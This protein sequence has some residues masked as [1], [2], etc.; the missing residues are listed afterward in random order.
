MDWKIW[1]LFMWIAISIDQ[2]GNTVCGALFNKVLITEEWH[3]FWDEDETISSAIWINK[4]L[5]TL[6]VL[7]KLLDR[8]LDKIDPNHS[9]KSIE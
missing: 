9:I 5:W 2:L 1:R 7:G 3:K 4:Q 6:K 8:I